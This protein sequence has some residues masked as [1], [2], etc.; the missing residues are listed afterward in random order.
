MF[1]KKKC[2]VLQCYL[3]NKSI[4]DVDLI[5]LISW[6]LPKECQKTVMPMIHTNLNSF[7][8]ALKKYQEEFEKELSDTEDMETIQES[9]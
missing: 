8:E 2:E 4:P 7:L 9:K 1:A 3:I 6:S 5:Q